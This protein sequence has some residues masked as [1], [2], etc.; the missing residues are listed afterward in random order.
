MCPNLESFGSLSVP[1]QLKEP[2][3][4]QTLVFDWYQKTRKPEPVPE[5]PVHISI[6]SVSGGKI[7]IFRN[8]IAAAYLPQ[9]SASS[10]WIRVSKFE[11]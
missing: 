3:K 11:V 6:S 10:P 5:V 8:L 4:I 7:W 2:P 1:F 9:L